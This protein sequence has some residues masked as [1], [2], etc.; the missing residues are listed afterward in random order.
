V[1]GMLEPSAIG[2]ADHTDA[3]VALLQEDA[4]IRDV[5]RMRTM[6]L[7]ACRDV[8]PG[9]P[10]TEATDDIPQSLL[11][12]RDWEAGEPSFPSVHLF[13]RHHTCTAS[14]ATSRKRP[15]SAKRCSWRT[16]AHGKADLLLVEET[17]GVTT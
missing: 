6:E 17:G 4:G 3:V 5:V 9:L 15:P 13:A 12:L 2:L 1:Y 16:P 8:A 7:E 10:A 14:S 11:A